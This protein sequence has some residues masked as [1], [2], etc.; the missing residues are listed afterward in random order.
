[1]DAVAPVKIRVGGCLALESL[2]VWRRRGRAAWEKMR[3]PL[4]AGR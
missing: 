1:M 4:L 3:A 2:V